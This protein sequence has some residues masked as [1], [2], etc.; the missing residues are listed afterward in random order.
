MLAANNVLEAIYD[1]PIDNTGFSYQPVILEKLPG[2]ADGDA[3]IQP[4]AVKENDSV[5]NDAGEIVLLRPG[6]QVRPY[7]CDLSKCAITWQGEALEMAQISATFTLKDNIRWSDGEPLSADDSVFGFE[8]ASSCRFPDDPNVTCGT[9]GA[10]GSKTAESTASYTAIDDRTTQ[11]VGLPGFLDQTYMTN[12]AH[13]LPRHELQTYTPNKFLD[14]EAYSPM[15]WGPYMIDE[16]KYGEYIHLSKNP[17]YYRASEGLPYFD[18]LIIRF[19]VRDEAATLS[20]LENGECD[21][22]DWE[23]ASKN[24]TLEHLVEYANNGK[25]LALITTGTT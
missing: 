4:V 21:L 25:L 23:Q 20:A 17:Y 2:L 10:D 3:T 15:G 24:I 9:L 19:F 7:G 16:W 6:Q 13:P 14:V 22:V 1:G 18:Q 11:W 8:K 5:V 12:F